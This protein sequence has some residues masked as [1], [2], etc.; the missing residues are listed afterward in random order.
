M[1]SDLLLKIIGFIAGTLIIISSI[2]QLITIIQNKSAKN[3]SMTMYYILLVAQ[4]AW[5]LYS[6]LKNDMIM[7][8]T[9][10]TA[11]CIT[12]LI[13]SFAMYYK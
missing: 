4:S 8:A 12:I 11:A 6:I 1:N 10:L 13:I 7:L 3:I 2:P 5:I 9:N